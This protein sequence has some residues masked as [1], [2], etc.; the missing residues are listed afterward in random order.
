MAPVLGIPSA[1]T[2]PER[3]GLLEA[4][5][6]NIYSWL[7]ARLAELLPVCSGCGE[8]C[9]F[10][11]FGHELWLTDIEFRL[12]MGDSSSSSTAGC[13]WL[14]GTACS[15]RQTRAIGCR[16]FYCTG[17]DARLHDLHEEALR[18]LRQ[19]AAD[20][21]HGLEY[22]ELRDLLERRRQEL[23]GE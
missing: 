8:C 11:R 22:S 9:A 17:D 7:D 2:S 20:L 19:S 12:L 3:L 6:R 5:L 16:T 15:A 1:L 23:S 4:E 18:R 13:P 14:C 10:A 21:G